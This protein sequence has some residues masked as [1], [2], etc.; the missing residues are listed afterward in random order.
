MKLKLYDKNSVVAMN[1]DQSALAPNVPGMTSDDWA[2]ILRINGELSYCLYHESRPNDYWWAMQWLKEWSNSKN[3]TITMIDIGGGE[4]MWIPY[5]K[6]EFENM[7]ATLCEKAVR[8]FP[9]PPVTKFP[10]DKVAEDGFPDST[11][12]EDNYDVVVTISAI[13]HFHKVKSSFLRMKELVR[14]GGLLLI[15]CDIEPGL[16]TA[17]SDNFKGY[18][19]ALSPMGIVDLLELDDE[20]TKIII[21]KVNAVPKSTSKRGKL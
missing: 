11:L 16:T 13:E 1:N 3:Q 15:T 10:P 18:V 9:K 21:D 8:D 5:A 4:S 17:I 6:K 19:N 7:H 2:D 12:L 14:P 20:D